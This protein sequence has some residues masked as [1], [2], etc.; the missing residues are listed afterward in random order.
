[1]FQRVRE[2]ERDVPESERER[3]VPESERER[4]MFQKIVRNPF[5]CSCKGKKAL[6][7]S[8]LIGHF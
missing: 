6:M 5:T 4:E 8:N 3:D 2:R 1:M 7:I